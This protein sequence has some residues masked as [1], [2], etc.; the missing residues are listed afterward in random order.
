MLSR[1]HLN[2]APFAPACERQ[3]CRETAWSDNSD[4]ELVRGVLAKDSVAIEVFVQRMQ[5][6]RRFLRS[7]NSRRGR[8]LDD[9]ALRD[10]EQDVLASVW[11]KLTHY[12]GDAEL[13]TWVYRFCD[14]QLRNAMR[15]AAPRRA[16]SL[17]D[18]IIDTREKGVEDS[19]DMLLVNAA[20]ESLEPLDARILH[21]KL[22]EMMTFDAVARRLARSPNTIKTRYYRAL[23]RLRCTVRGPGWRELRQRG[24]ACPWNCA[25]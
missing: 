20:L 2:P 17:D 22:F 15:R 7:A 5:C 13:T 16:L 23:H 18:N 6:I 11:R 10:V 8:P 1:R 21:L 12:T 19:D 9:D 14:L 4:V 3:P 24:S 25:S